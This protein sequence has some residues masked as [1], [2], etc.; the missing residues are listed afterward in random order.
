M[1]FQI[2]YN[3]LASQLLHLVSAVRRA[4][5]HASVRGELPVSATDLI[6]TI[7]DNTNATHA[8]QM[9]PLCLGTNHPIIQMNW[10][11]HLFQTTALKRLGPTIQCSCEKT[12]PHYRSLH[13]A[14][15]PVCC[16]TLQ[17]ASCLGRIKF[18]TSASDIEYAAASTF[19]LNVTRLLKLINLLRDTVPQVVSPSSEDKGR[20]Q[21]EYESMST[22]D[23]ALLQSRDGVCY[24]SIA[25][26][27]D[28][29]DAWLNKRIADI[30]DF[31][32]EQLPVGARA[33]AGGGSRPTEDNAMQNGSSSASRS[34]TSSRVPTA[35]S[36]GATAVLLAGSDEASRPQEG[37]SSGGAGLGDGDNAAAAAESG[38]PKSGDIGS[39]SADKR[40][41]IAPFISWETEDLV[42]W[43]RGPSCV[44]AGRG[45]NPFAKNVAGLISRTFLSDEYDWEATSWAA[46]SGRLKFGECSCSRSDEIRY[47]SACGYCPVC[48]TSVSCNEC[49]SRLNNI[50]GASYNDHFT[51]NHNM[52]MLLQVI[53]SVREATL[54]KDD[55][56][57]SDLAEAFNALPIEEQHWI[58]EN[59][60]LEEPARMAYHELESSDAAATNAWLNG[61]AR[62]MYDHPPVRLADGHGIVG[63]SAAA[64]IASGELPEGYG[65]GVGDI[66]ADVLSPV[67]DAVVEDVVFSISSSDSR[68]I[69]GLLVATDKKGCYDLMHEHYRSFPANVVVDSGSY[70][71]KYALP[72]LKTYT[73]G[74]TQYVKDA[75][76]NVSESRVCKRPSQHCCSFCLYYAKKFAAA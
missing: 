9:I 60:D 45:N 35:I 40:Y 25:F 42:A 51:F 21:A 32:P 75:R 53:G 64:S 10:S 30:R 7:G 57:Q 65:E 15:C 55:D 16:E 8:A 54:L 19:H 20:M 56:I 69:E 74:N 18:V 71:V 4:T 62:H 68:G 61:R 37:V 48:C 14:F 1:D 44:N 47:R 43:R 39:S 31:P 23:R 59:V 33:P 13:C 76:I 29:A 3:A 17:C 73:K 38:A 34:S 6:A 67:P 70:I 12:V 26:T 24:P 2:A 27:H 22:H 28:K 11:S 58:G 72:V 41:Y 50:A 46:G 36:R 49:S 52:R 5:P 63:S 66:D